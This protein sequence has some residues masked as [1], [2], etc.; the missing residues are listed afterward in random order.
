MRACICIHVGLHVGI[1]LHTHTGGAWCRS[2]GSKARICHRNSTQTAATSFSVPGNI[3]F[4]Y[5]SM[6]FVYAYMVCSAHRH[7]CRFM[8]DPYICNPDCVHVLALIYIFAHPTCSCRAFE[9]CTHIHSHTARQLLNVLCPRRYIH[10]LQDNCSM[11]YAHDDTFTYCK[12]T[13]Q[14]LCPRRPYVHTCKR[15]PTYIH[16]NV[17]VAY[18]QAVAQLAQAQDRIHGGKQKGS[19]SNG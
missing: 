11:F 13:A 2:L 3:L 6:L 14:C 15:I 1:L 5:V 8:L 17:Y 18:E 19:K 9:T 7:A 16:A 10:I 4:V 12:T